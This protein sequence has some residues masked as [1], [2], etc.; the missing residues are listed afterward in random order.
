MPYTNDFGAF[1][2]GAGA[3]VETPAT[4]AADSVFAQG[5][6]AGILPSVKLNT[7]L[8][9]S[10]SV[11]SMIGAFTALYGPGNVQ[12]NGNIATLRAQFEA[13]ILNYLVANGQAAIGGITLVPL[14]YYVNASTGSNSNTGLSLGT[15]F[16]TIQKAI[17]V[18]STI[19]TI[20]TTI[21]INVANGTYSN[22]VFSNVVGCAINL[23]GNTGSPSSC[24]I[25]TGGSGTF[26]C[27][28]INQV[29]ISIS[30]FQI[31][32][33]GGGIRSKNLSLV[34]IGNIIFNNTGTQAQIAYC[35]YSISGSVITANGPLTVNGLS[36]A[37]FLVAGQ[38]STIQVDNQTL[39][40]NSASFTLVSGTPGF[41]AWANGG[42]ITAAN[43]T[44]AG[45]VSYG[46][47]LE[48]DAGGSVY[49]GAGA[50]GALTYFPGT[51]AA[52]VAPG[53]YVG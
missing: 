36:L 3:N 28:C 24:I 11:A 5:F 15:A 25:N 51:I 13:A 30:G 37:A 53:C 16:A 1:A 40:A 33:I 42:A 4:W 29:Y 32:G 35:V 48:V 44:I 2:I 14:T 38:R 7:P 20:N 52:Y 43:V 21:T 22:F 46:Q 26:A 18:A 8:R 10:T 41:Y 31:N 50:A 45:T 23:V 9:Q 12:D 27:D 34:T 6:Q 19:R 39:T 17:D 47:R 49:T